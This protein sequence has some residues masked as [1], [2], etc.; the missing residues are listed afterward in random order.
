LLAPS[1]EDSLHI[2]RLMAKG[3]RR[4]YS[5]VGLTISAISLRQPHQCQNKVCNPHFSINDWEA[6]LGQDALAIPVR[7]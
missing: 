4:T 3:I 2:D 7:P 6:L 1:V 5:F